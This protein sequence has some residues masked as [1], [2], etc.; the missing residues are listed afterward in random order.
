MTFLILSWL[1]WAVGILGVGGLAALF[2]FAPA[3]AAVAMNGIAKAI[4]AILSTRIGVGLFALAAGLI[5]GEMHALHG[6]EE[7]CQAR[8]DANNEAWQ[9]RQREAKRAHDLGRVRR[10]SEIGA[11]TRS[12]V[13]A[14]I[15]SLN[16]KNATLQS[17][18]KADA[19]ERPKA[20]ACRVSDD[21]VRRRDRLLGKP[22]G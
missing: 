8:L 19:A 6:A 21:L 20:P 14:L 15:A 9:E 18:V 13:D 3:L 2:F 17:Q 7:A 22:K 1:L 10:D 5:A 4:Q 12:N 11:D 16:A